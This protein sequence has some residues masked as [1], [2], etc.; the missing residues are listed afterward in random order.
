VDRLGKEKF[1][2]DFDKRFNAESFMIVVKHSGLN[3]GDLASFRRGVRG[4]G[5][6]FQVVKN[7]LV[8]KAL[9]GQSDEIVRAFR[10]PVGVVLGSDAVGSSKVVA[11]FCKKRESQIQIVMGCLD[12]VVLKKDEVMRLSSLPSLEELRS[13][14][15]RAIQGSATRLVRIFAEPASALARVVD[16]RSRQ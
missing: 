6:V 2:E 15:L 14:L 10:G 1:L 8:R 3:A 9:R 13:Q 12:G 4:S 7:S 11:D 5:A 16:A